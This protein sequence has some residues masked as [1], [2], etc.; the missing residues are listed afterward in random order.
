MPVIESLTEP[1]TGADTRKSGPPTARRQ[2]RSRILSISPAA[3]D[4]AE[5]R[6]VLQDMP[7]QVVA[8]AT[9]REAVKYLSRGRPFATFCESNLPD[10]TWK[11]I[12]DYIQGSGEP[13]LVIVTSR[14]ADGY[15][16]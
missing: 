11:D 2:S 9:C 6:R 16:W 14:L 4:H 5:L 8:T 1:T 12:L 10:G 7:F 15:L 3:E 13:T